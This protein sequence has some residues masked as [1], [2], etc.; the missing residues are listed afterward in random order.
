MKKKINNGTTFLNVLRNFDYDVHAFET[1]RLTLVKKNHQN[2][3]SQCQTKSFKDRKI[4]I[5]AV[6][7]FCTTN[8]LYESCRIR[9]FYFIKDDQIYFEVSTV[10]FFQPYEIE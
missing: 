4:L 7:K 10:A 5:K 3:R 1:F 9:K 2:C 8:Q 6:L